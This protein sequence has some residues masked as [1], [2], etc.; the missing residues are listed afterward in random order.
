MTIDALRP[1][2]IDCLK[3]TMQC[4]FT[5]G[6]TLLR[7]RSYCRIRTFVCVLEPDTANVEDFPWHAESNFFMPS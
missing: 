3:M 4:G 6:Y 7:F 1:Q 2:A 5:R